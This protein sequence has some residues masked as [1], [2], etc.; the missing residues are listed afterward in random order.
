MFN[1]RAIM[2]II[3]RCGISVIIDASTKPYL[4]IYLN[5]TVLIFL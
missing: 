5:I 2:N 1:F 4:L 3:W